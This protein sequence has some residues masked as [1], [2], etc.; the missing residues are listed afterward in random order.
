MERWDDQVTQDHQA[1]EAQVGVL[2]LILTED[3]AEQDRRGAFKRFIRAIGPALVLHLRKEEQVLFPALEKLSG[4]KSDAIVVLREQH[5]Q[6][7]VLLKYLAELE[8]WCGCGPESFDWKEVA[9]AGQRFVNLL[10]E[11]ERREDQLLIHV[12]ESSL[13][14][15]EL[16]NLARAFQQI[17]W[18][19]FQEEV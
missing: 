8:C 12:L 16:K 9:R 7:L 19:I 13:K 5:Q 1:L 6:L 10:E 17:V 15:Q 3:I 2:K 11:H 18:Q 14:P 4:E